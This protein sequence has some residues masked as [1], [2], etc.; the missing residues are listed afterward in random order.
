MPGT[1]SPLPNVR[2]A[3]SM[4]RER[5]VVASRC[6]SDV[7]GALAAAGRFR[8][9]SASRQDL[10]YCGTAESVTALISSAASRSIA[11]HGAI[12]PMNPGH[13]HSPARR[14]VA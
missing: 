8:R 3:R 13:G 9:S 5:A 7:S 14:R 1:L 4:R 6:S 2:T 10:S 11:L 12:R